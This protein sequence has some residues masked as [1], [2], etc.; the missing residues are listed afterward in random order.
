MQPLTRS[1][2]NTIYKLKATLI[3]LEKNPKMNF[4]RL[5]MRVPPYSLE[6][7][8]LNN[9]LKLPP[10]YMSKNLNNKYRSRR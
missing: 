5:L 2:S 4:K 10:I 1:I 3:W 6:K 7:K 9:G 8:V